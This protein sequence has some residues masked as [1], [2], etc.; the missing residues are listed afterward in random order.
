MT[1]KL[2][3]QQDALA[4]LPNRRMHVYHPTGLMLADEVQWPAPSLTVL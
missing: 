2:D 4:S 1:M 3:E